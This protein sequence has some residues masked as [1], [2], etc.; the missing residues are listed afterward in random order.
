MPDAKWLEGYAGQSVE[1]LLAF[2][3]EYRIDS[4][5]LAFEQALDQKAARDGQQSLNITERTILA[6]EAL[7]REV[8]NGGYGQFFLNSSREYASIVVDSLQTIGCSKTAEITQKAIGS[9]HLAAP[10]TEGIEVVMADDNEERDEE[11]NRCDD[12]YYQAGENIA[13]QLFVF[14]K[15]NKN[16]IKP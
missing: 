1:Q 6:V 13:G 7:E 8:N 16:A 5:V 15:A 12:L 4:L 10:T 3:G 14:I 9:L 2:E 11:L